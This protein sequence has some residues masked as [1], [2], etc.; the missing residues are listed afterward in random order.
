MRRK[1]RHSARGR[2]ARGGRRF[3]AASAL[4]QVC[5]IR[6]GPV[7]TAVLLVQAVLVPPAQ[8]WLPCRAAA[9]ALG[10]G[11]ARARLAP[12]RLAQTAVRNY[13]MGMH[14]SASHAAA[15]PGPH[16]MG[17]SGSAHLRMLSSNQHA[18]G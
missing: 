15:L 11:T 9:G 13:A 6:A 3:P 7:C 8:A 1:L 4:G 2:A 12:A 5:A 10:L 14:C 18:Q 16:I 17:T